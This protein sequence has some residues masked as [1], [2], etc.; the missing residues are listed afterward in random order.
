[1]GCQPE[2][3]ALRGKPRRPEPKPID[4]CLSQPTSGLLVTVA[5]ITIVNVLVVGISISEAWNSSP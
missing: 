5:N 3:H 4:I 2:K 1:M